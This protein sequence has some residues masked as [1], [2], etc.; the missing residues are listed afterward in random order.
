MSCGPEKRDSDFSWQEFLYC[1]NSE[2]LG[3]Y[4]NFINRTL[5]FIKNSFSSTVPNGSV[6]NTIQ[7]QIR[8]L[9]LTTGDDITKGEIKESLKRIF[10]FIRVANKYFDGDKPWITLGTDIIKCQNTLYNCVYIIINLA[11]LLE[12]YLPE[13]SKKILKW[14]KF[15]AKWQEQKIE[16]GFHIPEFGILFE[17]LDKKI[18]D[19]ELS[20]LNNTKFFN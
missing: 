1:N 9:Y 12:P 13:S 19:N 5:A 11:I 3:T 10:T 20:K 15:E 16:A 14:F 8:E 18:V 6:E 2:L 7:S 17:R 4:G